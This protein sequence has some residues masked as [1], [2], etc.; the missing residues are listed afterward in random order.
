MASLLCHLHLRRT[1]SKDTKK[2]CKVIHHRTANFLTAPS[3]LIRAHTLIKDRSTG[4]VPR[5]VSIR[6]LSSL[7]RG[8]FSQ[9]LLRHRMRGIAHIMKV[10]RYEMGEWLL[11]GGCDQVPVKK[12]CA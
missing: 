2:S 9:A 11:L 7:V 10:I 1:L 3:I 4:Q 12:I 6:Y 5:Q 8:T